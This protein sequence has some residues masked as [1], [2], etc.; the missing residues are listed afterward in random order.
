MK[1]TG[2]LAAALT[3]GF[4][5]CTT[6]PLPADDATTPPLNKRKKTATATSRHERRERQNHKRETVQKQAGTKPGATV[7]APNANSTPGSTAPGH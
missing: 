1:R 7:A 6:A 2:L 5:L 4:F 3:A